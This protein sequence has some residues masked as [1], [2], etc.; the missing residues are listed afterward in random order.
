[1][2]VRSSTYD[3]GEGWG[4]IVVQVCSPGKPVSITVGKCICHCNSRNF[5]SAFQKSKCMELSAHAPLKLC[6]KP[7]FLFV[8]LVFIL[9]PEVVLNFH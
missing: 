3:Q 6:I 8:C 2:T 1:M 7:R 5:G 4:K 9:C